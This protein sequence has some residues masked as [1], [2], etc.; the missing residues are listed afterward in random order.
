MIGSCCSWSSLWDNKDE[1]E[2]K[3][4]EEKEEEGENDDNA[5]SSQTLDDDIDPIELVEPSEHDTLNWE[6]ERI[7]FSSFIFQW[8]HKTLVEKSASTV[9]FLDFMTFSQR[10]EGII[11]EFLFFQ[12]SLEF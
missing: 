3:D 8:S 4:N 5:S 11:G 1:V 6:W 10:E 2:D 12:F 7:D 9:N